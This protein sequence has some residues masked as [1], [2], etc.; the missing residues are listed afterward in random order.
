MRAWLSREDSLEASW[1]GALRDPGLSRTLARVHAEPGRPWTVAGLAEIAA[2][3]RAAFARR[4]TS[5]VGT[6]P[7]AYVAARRLDRAARMLRETDQ[8]LAAIAS[9]VGYDSEFALSR[10]FKRSRGLAP[11]RYRAAA[12]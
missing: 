12:G 1:L 6:T 5:M 2:M 9:A 7:L 3:S 11:G 4:F 10:A 8:P